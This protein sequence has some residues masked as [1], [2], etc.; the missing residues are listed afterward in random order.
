VRASLTARARSLRLPLLL[1]LVSAVAT[2]GYAGIY[3]SSAWSGARG[4]GSAGGPGCP[5]H[6]FWGAPP[7][8][9]LLACLLGVASGVLIAAVGGIVLVGRLDARRAGYGVIALSAVGVAAYG[10]LVIGTVAG[11]L[12][13]ALLLRRRASRAIAPTEWTGSLPTGVPP[14]AQGPKRPLT[15]RPPVTEWRGIFAT[16]PLGP[17]TRGR[18]PVTLPT[19]DR[20]SAAL[21]RSRAASPAPSPGQAPPVVVLP[22]PP[23]GLRSV[24][25][26]GP[27]LAYGEPRPV[28]PPGPSPLATPP[29][30]RGSGKPAVRWRAGA[31]DVAPGSA[32]P[33]PTPT[34]LPARS[35]PPPATVRPG[36]AAGSSAAMPARPAAAR[37]ELGPLRA[38]RAAPIAPGGAGAVPP[39]VAPLPTVGAVSSSARPTLLPTRGLGVGGVPGPPVARPPPPKGPIAKA[40][41]KAWKCPKCGLV[42]APWTPRCTKCRTNAP[43]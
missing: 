6:P 17:P 39:A 21:E 38:P 10:G 13:G 12:A 32:P 25:P 31:S 35:A 37:P 19:A 9:Y 7:A 36:P 43:A 30:S 18:P 42:N 11:V 8:L 23:I 28:R 41:T 3:L 24:V 29:P 22:P 4:C 14:V 27:A 33:L 5:P 40:R 16:A 34:S 26:R 1:C 20:L 15:S 2:A